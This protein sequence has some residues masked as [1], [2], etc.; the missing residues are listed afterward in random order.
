M[1]SAQLSMP[2][3]S[4]DDQ[5]Q[6]GSNG[7]AHGTAAPARKRV[8]AESMATKQRE[9]SVSEFFV[10]NRHLLGFDNPRKALLTTVKEAVDN[11][12]DACEE[13]GILPEIWVEIAQTGE[14]RYAISVQDNGPGIVPK[15][16][17]NIFGKLLYGSKFHR[18]RMSRGQQGIGISAAGMYGLLTTGKPVK[19][20]SK[21]SKKKPGFYCELQINTKINRPEILNNKG[22]GLEIPTGEDGVKL[23]TDHGVHFEPVEHGNARHDRVGRQIPSRARLRRRISRTDVHRQPARQI[24]FRRAR[25]SEA[26]VRARGRGAAAGSDRD[27]AASLR[28]RVGHADQ[29]DQAVRRNFTHAIPHQLVLPRDRSDRQGDLRRG[30]AEREGLS[31]ED[32]PRRVRNALQGF[33][34]NNHPAPFD[35]LHRADR[36]GVVADRLE[37]SHRAGRI[38]LR[39]HTAAGR[40]S[41]QPVSD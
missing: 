18:L 3:G 15:Q 28:G 41:R 16:V 25:R 26:H 38:S 17:P 12:L 21:T 13:A 31:Q 24:A 29:Y 22:E 10:K 40:L 20:V 7:K 6:N 11:S 37:A 30:E 32:R 19:I 33:A 14:N 5:S 34:R 36:R 39:R 2:L 27:Q 4:D 35:R 9:I 23:L 8:S 1:S